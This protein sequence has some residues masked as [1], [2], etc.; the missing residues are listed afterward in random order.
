MRQIQPVVNFLKFLFEPIS[1]L[2][3]HVCNWL[4]ILLWQSESFLKLSAR[5]DSVQNVPYIDFE[6]T[7]L[8]R[9]YNLASGSTCNV[10]NGTS[11][12]AALHQSAIL[13]DLNGEISSNFNS[14]FLPYEFWIVNCLIHEETML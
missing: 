6:I 10:I 8:F 11:V 5:A 13:G 14:R 4:S 2:R 12:E 3:W 1:W 9:N 7:E